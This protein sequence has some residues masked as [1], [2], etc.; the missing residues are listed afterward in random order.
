MAMAMAMA[1]ALMMMLML[2]RSH[3]VT[4]TYYLCY[5]VFD[6]V[7]ANVEHLKFACKKIPLRLFRANIEH[8]F[9]RYKENIYNT[10]SLES[11]LM[12]LFFFSIVTLLI[13]KK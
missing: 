8:Q 3:L 4:R 11:V 5:N 6:R 7:R 12:L 9:S 10:F 1:M 2:M 13:R